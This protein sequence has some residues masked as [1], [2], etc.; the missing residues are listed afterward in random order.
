MNYRCKAHD[1]R[2]NLK[3]LKCHKKGMYVVHPIKS[4]IIVNKEYNVSR[5]CSCTPLWTKSHETSW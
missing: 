4:H 1:R 2:L 3:K 5:E